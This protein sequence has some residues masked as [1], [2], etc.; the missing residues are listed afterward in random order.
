M[1]VSQATLH[2]VDFIAEKDI[3]IGDR[4]L[5]KRAGDVIPYV[6]GPVVEA[7]RGDEKP[8]TLPERCPSCGEQLERLPGEVA[9][10]CVNAACPAQLVRNLEHFA[11]RSA[12][13]IEGLGI[14]IA[15]Q[16]VE[17]DL[18][19]DVADIYRLNVNDLLSL[20]GFAKKKPEG[21]NGPGDRFPELAKAAGIEEHRLIKEPDVGWWL[22]VRK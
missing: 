11:S 20:E 6:I 2:N 13:D 4:V 1:T 8:Y 7:R 3:R 18:V 19:S 9:V 10:Y 12:M 5:V 21:W 15:K 17:A 16:F 14:K 22:E